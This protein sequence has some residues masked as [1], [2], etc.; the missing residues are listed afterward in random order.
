MQLKPGPNSEILTRPKEE[1][2][3]L[4]RKY[5]R[6]KI[7]RKLQKTQAG[8]QKTEKSLLGINLF[9]KKWSPCTRKDDKLK[10][11][12]YLY[13]DNYLYCRNSLENV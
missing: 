1:C 8:C 5:K 9:P 4:A 2:K 7:K 3:I 6:Q 11:L 10:S 13:Y 12:W